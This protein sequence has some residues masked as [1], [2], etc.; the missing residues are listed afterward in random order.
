MGADSIFQGY[1]S[2]I[3]MFYLFSFLA[4]ILVIIFVHEFGHFIVGRWCGVKVDVFSLG[5]GRELW[6]FNDKHGTRWKLSAIPLGGYVKF[7]GDANAASQP[8]RNNLSPTSLHAQSVAKRAAIVAAG[9]IA[10]FI[11]AI[12][13]FTMSFMIAGVSYMEPVIS[14]VV[15][16]SAADRAGLKPGDIVQ[17]IDGSAITSFEDL[18][19]S[20]FFRAGEKLNVTLSRSGSPVS[21]QLVP[22]PK[23]IDDGFGGK[24][25]I[26]LMGVKHNPGPSEPRYRQYNL[27]EAFNKATDRTWLIISTTGKIVKHMIT[28]SQSVKQVGG[29]VSMAKG[30]GDQASEGGWA[31]LMYVGFLS[32]SIGLINLFPVPMLDGGHLVY[33]A[34]EAVRGKPLGQ[35]AQEWGYRIGFSVVIMLMAL[36]LFN[37][38]GRLI[39]WHFGT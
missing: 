13:I 22:E 7:E 16:G 4:A 11:L 15:S 6:G 21:V 23:E 3:F 24:V 1:W 10:N 12:A 20:V 25:T 19:Q 31:F 32:V 18:Q 8:D 9:P 36:G 27:T 2:L 33:F 39:S 29:A 35:Q 34:I 30:A 28:G 26:G 17:D 38:A 37:D 14:E 5:F